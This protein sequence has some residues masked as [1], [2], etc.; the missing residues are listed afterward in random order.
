[1][2][3]QKKGLESTRNSKRK[4]QVGHGMR[5]D[6]RRTTRIQSNQ[7]VD[8]ITGQRMTVRRYLKG[9]LEELWD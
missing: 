5:A 3:S 1:M 9:F 2:E 4:K 6:K 7:V 8:H